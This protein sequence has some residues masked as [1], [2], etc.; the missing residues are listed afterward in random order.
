LNEGNDVTKKVSKDPLSHQESSNRER[1]IENRHHEVRASK[2]SN[3][4]VDSGSSSL[5]G[6]DSP[7][8]KEISDA[9][10]NDNQRIQNDDNS[11]LGWK[12]L[13]SF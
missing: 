6:K 3:E 1:N 13:L 11:V 2:V 10:D 8:D 5:A 12:L 9:R 7:N 4:N